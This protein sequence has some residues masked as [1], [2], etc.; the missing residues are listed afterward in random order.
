MLLFSGFGSS[1]FKTPKLSQEA[2]LVLKTISSVFPLASETTDLFSSTWFRKK[3][4][5]LV[6]EDENRLQFNFGKVA[7]CPSEASNQRRWWKLRFVS[8]IGVFA[9]YTSF[10]KDMIRCAQLRL[11]KVI[12]S[13][14]AIVSD[15]S[16]QAPFLYQKIL[17]LWNIVRFF[18]IKGK[19]K[20]FVDLTY[21]S[22]P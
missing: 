19:T 6:V 1:F 15:G 4:W 3:H 14:R 13:E 9:F 11:E 22:P 20:L 17:A 16:N 10:S 12:G 5:I 21:P 18:L 2:L 7:I 8:A